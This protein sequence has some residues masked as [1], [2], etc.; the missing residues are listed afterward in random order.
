MSG[1]LNIFLCQV[2]ESSTKAKGNDPAQDLWDSSVLEDV[3]AKA[4]NIGKIKL[5]LLHYTINSIN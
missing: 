2:D 3:P 5:R 1:L 4:D